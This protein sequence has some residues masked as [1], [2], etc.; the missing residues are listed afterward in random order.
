MVNRVYERQQEVFMKFLTA[1]LLICVSVAPAAAQQPGWIGITIGDGNDQGAIIQS[2]QA[3]SPAEKAGL[4]TGDLVLEYNKTPVLGSVQLTRL[5]RETPPGRAVEVKVRRDNRDQTVSVT[6][7][8][9]DNAFD[10][11][12]VF[13]GDGAIRIGPDRSILLDNLYNLKRDTS[14]MQVWMSFSRSGIRVDNMTNQLRNFFGV[15]GEAGVLVASV[16][17]GSAAEKAGLKA[18]DVVT[19][20]DNRTVRTP[21]EFDR[22]MRTGSTKISLRIVRDKKEQDIT[23]ERT[24]PTR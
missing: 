9:G 20:V 23:I 10:R 13:S 14:Q 5:V 4:K 24:S 3:N 18:G 12:R 22:E 1:F 8:R 15:T 19:A 2:V 17:P 11:L 6:T 21:S 16:D 7:E